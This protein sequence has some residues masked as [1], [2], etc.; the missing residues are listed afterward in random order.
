M[1][2]AV[3]STI[4]EDDIARVVEA[5][6]SLGQVE[7]CHLIRRGFNDVY[8]VRLRGGLRYVARLT[9]LRARGETNIA[10]ETA[11]LAHLKVEGSAVGAPVLTRSGAM[12]RELEAPE[13][14]RVLAVFEHLEGDPRVLFS[15]ISQPWA[16]VSRI[17]TT[18]GSDTQGRPACIGWTSNICVHGRWPGC[19][20]RPQST[21]IWLKDSQPRPLP[22]RRVFGHSTWRR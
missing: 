15:S 5:T 20:P 4:R 6:Y 13:G 12:W 18:R 3:Y 17:S 19:W 21:L 9:D 1:L 14:R 8:A 22:W 2:R 16:P 11:F 10:F 7:T